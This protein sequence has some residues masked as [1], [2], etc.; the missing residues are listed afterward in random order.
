MTSIYIYIYIYVRRPQHKPTPVTETDKK[1]VVN[2]SSH[3]LTADQQKVLSLGPKFCP[4]PRSLDHQQLS[5][6]VAEGC[7]R[8]RLR[9][10]FFQPD[11]P[12]DAPAPPKFYKK[13]GFKPPLGRDRSLDAFCA[14]LQGRVQSHAAGA[15]CPRD[16]LSGCQRQAL[17]QLRQLVLNRT[18]RISMADKGG[19]VVIQDTADYIAEA[20][21]QLGNAA[22]YQVLG[23][24]PTSKIARASNTLATK[25]RND[26]HL[27]QTT[28]DWALVTP[29]DTRCHQFYMLPKIHKTLDKP[30][31]RP[32]ISG[33]AGPTENLSKLVAHWL[34]AVVT[35]LPSFI[36]DSTHML[37]TL[38]YWNQRYGPFPD[39]TRLV[40]IDVV[41]L[42]T[43]IPHDEMLDSIR[44]FLRC[45]PPTDRPPT[46]R[47]V[48]I[49]E[50]VLTNNVFTFE[51]RYYKQV[52]G[53]A[54]GTPM[55]PAGA[56]L[57]MGKLES[58]LLDSSPVPMSADF[59]KRFIDDI[60][61]LWTDS[62]DNLNLFLDHINSLHPTIKF[63]SSVSSESIPFLDINIILKN[64][65]LHSDLYSKPTD[66]HAYLHASSC[67]P[68]H[69]INN[70]PYGQ[71]LRLRRLCSDNDTFMTRCDA[72][73]RWFLERGHKHATITQAREKAADIPRQQ[74]L[75]Y[76]QNPTNNRVPI[77]IT[78]H[79]SNPPIKNGQQNSLKMSSTIAHA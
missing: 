11:C 7:R 42:Y 12:D 70:M 33:V 40:T 5:E 58:L 35:R 46:D 61:L 67:H 6:D 15:N 56:N 3:S 72:M 79:P 47:I 75:T 14:A 77:V 62:L 71:F 64:D 53:T 37:Q 27:D 32:I 78:H 68:G 48:E 44:H 9:E 65:Y 41:S 69:T 13:T 59:W 38:D 22:S 57:F 26:G 74:A 20:H 39:S 21:R 63:T 17:Q 29:S 55:A 1:T 34:Q 36:K 4:T 2:L 51:D 54:M 28:L 19:A 66:A 50:H 31:G 23:K 24:D 73:T 45:S 30:P 8:I 60:F 16:N 43:N 52:Q 25:L 18:I 76:K 10:L 49:A